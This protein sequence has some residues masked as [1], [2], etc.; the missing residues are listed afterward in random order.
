MLLLLPA[1]SSA[2]LAVFAVVLV[3]GLLVALLGHLAH[4]RPLIV[5]GIIVIGAVSAYFSFVLQPTG[6]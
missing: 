3:L 5:A 6:R 2:H 4:S 1:A